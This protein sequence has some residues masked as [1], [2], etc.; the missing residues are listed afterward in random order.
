MVY[1]GIESVKVV[2]RISYRRVFAGE[3]RSHIPRW[4]AKRGRRG[5]VSHSP[6][7]LS[8]P[9]EQAYPVDDVGGSSL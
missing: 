5:V 9:T 6:S 4:A 2:A 3:R 8:S 7:S 1:T